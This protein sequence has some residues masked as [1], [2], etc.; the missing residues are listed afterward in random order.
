MGVSVD[1]TDPRVENSH[2]S[3][4]NNDGENREEGEI[5]DDFEDIISSDEEWSMR[6]RIEELEARNSELEK[7]ENISGYYNYGSANDR[8][9]GHPIITVSDSE[10]YPHSSATVHHPKRRKQ[11]PTSVLRQAERYQLHSPVVFKPARKRDYD[12]PESADRSLRDFR[13]SRKRKYEKSTHAR[14]PRKK[15]RLKSNKKTKIDY[16]FSSDEEWCSLDRDELRLALRHEPVGIKLPGNLMNNVKEVSKEN[17]KAEEEPIEVNDDNSDKQADSDDSESLEIQEL[18][19]IALKSAFLKKNRERKQ[20]KQMEEKKPYSPTDCLQPIVV[21]DSDIPSPKHFLDNEPC[22]SMD[23]SPIASPISVSDGSSLKPVDMD[24]VDSSDSSCPEFVDQRPHWTSFQP[25]DEIPLPNSQNYE[26]DYQTLSSIPTNH[27]VSPVPIRVQ[28][29][30]VTIPE[31]IDSA[32]VETDEDEKVEIKSTGNASPEPLDEEVL[33]LRALLLAQK[34]SPKFSKD[35]VKNKPNVP[36]EG[37]KASQQSIIIDPLEAIMNIT[38]GPPDKT[39]EI[40]KEAVKRLQSKSVPNESKESRECDY[41]TIQSISR[42]DSQ[43]I[44]NVQY[45]RDVDYRIPN[46]YMNVLPILDSPQKI[47]SEPIDAVQ[48]SNLIDCQSVTKS[49]K[50]KENIYTAKRSWPNNIQIIPT[51]SVQRPIRKSPLT[52]ITETGNVA[53]NKSD[54]DIKPKTLD[55]PV[56]LE[57]NVDLPTKNPIVL[58]SAN[59]LKPSSANLIK[60]QNSSSKSEVKKSQ[61]QAKVPAVQP[62]S[63]AENKRQ[64]KKS[65]TLEALQLKT[66]NLVSNGKLISSNQIIAAKLLNKAIHKSVTPIKRKTVLIRQNPTS[67]LR[68]AKPSENTRLITSIDVPPV[69]RLVINLNA[70]SESESDESFD[71]IVDKL[72]D[73]VPSTNKEF[74]DISSP[75][76]LSLESPC[77]SPTECVVGNSSLTKGANNVMKADEPIATT[78]ESIQKTKADGIF[79]AKLEEFLKNARSM[80]EKDN[81]SPKEK[82]TETESKAKTPETEW[83]P[84]STSTPA[85]VRHLPLSSQLEYRRLINRMQALEKQKLARNKKI[86]ASKG[87]SLTV[88]INNNILSTPSDPPVLTKAVED[89]KKPFKSKPIKGSTENNFIKRITHTEGTASD[90]KKPLDS[91]LNS[92]QELVI[93]TKGVKPVSVTA[94]ASVAKTTQMQV[95]PTQVVSNVVKAK[96]VKKNLNQIKTKATPSVA[97]NFPLRAKAATKLQP[98]KALVNEPKTVLITTSQVIAKT[99]PLRKPA[100]NLTN[101]NLIQNKK[102]E[103]S[104]LKPSLELKTEVECE[105]EFRKTSSDLVENIRKTTQMVV[106]VR[107]EKREKIRLEH[108]LEKLKKAVLETETKIKEKEQRTSIILPKISSSYKGI[109]VLKDRTMQ[110][111]Q[112]S[113]DLCKRS[114]SERNNSF[115]MEQKKKINFLTKELSLEIKK[116]KEVGQS[117]EMELLTDE[118]VDAETSTETD[119]LD[120]AIQVDCFMESTDSRISEATACDSLTSVSLKNNANNVISMVSGNEHCHD[121]NLSSILPE[122]VSDKSSPDDTAGASN[123]ITVET[124]QTEESSMSNICDIQNVQSRVDSL[125][126]NDKMEPGTLERRK[127][128]DEACTSEVIAGPSNAKMHFYNRICGANELEVK[129]KSKGVLQHSNEY[130]SPLDFPSSSGGSFNPNGIIC[131]YQLMGQCDDKEC[132]YEHLNT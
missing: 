64:R 101:S 129:E 110:L 43:D 85:A 98:P 96:V 31:E 15:E 107:D 67:T 84:K 33:A 109:L 28:V 17:N 73:R 1:L 76:S 69:K 22:N 20:R 70:K 50:V 38:H 115:Y 35:S 45:P 123:E 4:G 25:I 65:T 90:E 21:V 108:E 74:Y 62:S 49:V 46:F 5:V 119:M 27:I 51:K 128:V 114:D 113:I 71:D 59:H 66:Q 57:S 105:A 41:S 102:G 82:T 106:A 78:S 52:D 2:G 54:A 95:K 130:V 80:S 29:P 94:K 34:N 39:A 99:V 93:A 30:A 9:T 79:E 111:N 131:P 55:T 88:T 91:Q 44:A 23:I 61:V 92:N 53:V 68:T 14:N 58:G 83:K 11:A 42:D 32:C 26:T 7:L 63:L 100:N 19:L 56:K 127:A 40:L 112:L 104:I 132:K 103:S 36:V 122:L 16:E 18:R 77:D 3:R 75:K 120:K 60:V 48:N 121:P 12:P 37:S 86:T 81:D 47:P 89:V 8:Y 124:E 87:N 117:D 97:T 126:S 24:L 116:L 10:D 125:R 72:A 6:K 118:K 13:K